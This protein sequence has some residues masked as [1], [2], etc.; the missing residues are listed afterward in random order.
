MKWD[1]KAYAQ[2][3][4]IL[5]GYTGYPSPADWEFIA[6]HYGV[7]GKTIE[8]RA[9]EGRQV[10][11]EF[12]WKS[13]PPTPTTTPNA[14]L[15]GILNRIARIE[16]LLGERLR[17]DQPLVAPKPGQLWVTRMREH[18]E[19]GRRVLEVVSIEGKMVRLREVGG[20]TLYVL[21]TEILQDE[22]VSIHGGARL[23]EPS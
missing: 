14:V 10:M 12:P 2:L 18:D 4:E 11:G 6:T 9:R 17:K 3:W 5:Q 19:Q 22:F 20:D 15:L 8:R 7:T 1:R 23:S 13:S 21:P 16:D